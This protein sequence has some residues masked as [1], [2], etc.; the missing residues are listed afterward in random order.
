MDT[1]IPLTP[2]T[3]DSP[4]VK[5]TQPEMILLRR[6]LC[7]THSTPFTI[8]DQTGLEI[9]NAFVAIR[10]DQK[11][12]GAALMSQGELFEMINLARCFAIVRGDHSLTMS[13]WNDAVGIDFLRRD[14]ISR[15]SK[16]SCSDANKEQG[17]ICTPTGMS[18]G[19][20]IVGR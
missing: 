8:T 12:R 20:Q 7:Q 9:Q 3:I 6:Y 18:I 5:L 13:D 17:G 14:R 19:D 2:I 11:T 10:Q 4:S 15:I 1:H 16:T